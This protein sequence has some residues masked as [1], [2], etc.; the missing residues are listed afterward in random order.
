MS[1]RAPVEF[2]S[3]F[4]DLTERGLGQFPVA[5]VRI[6]HRVIAATE[7]RHNRSAKLEDAGWYD[8]RALNEMQFDVTVSANGVAPQTASVTK[9]AGG[10]EDPND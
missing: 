2:C 6:L 3:T 7:A 8:R 4:E 5:A 10:D 9:D 1:V